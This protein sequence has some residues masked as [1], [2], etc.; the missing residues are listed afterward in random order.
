MGSGVRGRVDISALACVPRLSSRAE[1]RE[2]VPPPGI[3][4]TPSPS[5]TLGRGEPD[6][7]CSRYL[8]LWLFATK[9][10]ELSL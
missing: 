6:L 7:T 9:L 8:R 10:V 1:F 5:P 4:L 2:L 3:P